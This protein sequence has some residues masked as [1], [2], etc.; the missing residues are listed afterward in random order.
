MVDH[1][2]TVVGPDGP[3]AGYSGRYAFTA[4]GKAGEEVRFDKPGTDPEV[5]LCNPSIN[6]DRVASGGGPQP[7]SLV[8]IMVNDVVLLHNFPAQLF[9][10]LLPAQWSMQA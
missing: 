6:L 10:K 3:D 8:R 4:A 7:D 9:N 5:S 1:L 2:E